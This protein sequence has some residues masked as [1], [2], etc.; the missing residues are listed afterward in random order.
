MTG[1]AS[2]RNK[3]VNTDE[4]FSLTQKFSDKLAA[5][6]RSDFLA[7]NAENFHEILPGQGGVYHIAEKMNG[8]FKTIYIGQS[9]NLKK[10]EFI[11]IT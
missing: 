7:F 10:I 4:I 6:L 2:E 3:F 8:L 9:K 5:L 1:S 11:G